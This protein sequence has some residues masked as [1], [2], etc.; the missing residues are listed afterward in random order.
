MRFF[1]TKNRVIKPCFEADVYIDFDFG[2]SKYDGII[3]DAVAYGF[4][5]EVRGGYIVPTYKDTRVTYKELVSKDEIWDTFLDKFNE[6]SAKKMAYRSKSEDVLAEIEEEVKAAK[7][8]KQL[9]VEA[10]EDVGADIPEA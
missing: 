9:I 3:K 4:I 6:E 5:Q 10:S 1:C 7:K 2:I 8:E